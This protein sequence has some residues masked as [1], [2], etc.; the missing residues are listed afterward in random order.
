MSGLPKLPIEPLTQAAF[1]PFGEVIETQGR[2]Y[3]FI[4][5]G[6]T[7]RY[8][9][10]AAAQTERPQDEVI[11]SIFQARRTELPLTIGMLERHPLGSQ[12]F[13]PL[14]ENPFLIVVAPLGDGVKSG[15]IR[16]FR[17]NGRQ[18][19]NYFK[20]VWHHPLLALDDGDRFLVI[21]RAGVGEN[22]DE[23]LLSA[24]QQLLLADHGGFRDHQS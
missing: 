5:N 14:Q 12:A 16:A 18:G 24:A 1:A 7:R 10:L 13:V 15:E 20:G 22:C 19:V 6:A 11:I 23:Y 3:F 8:H 21:D 2:D 9:R 17:S 4:N